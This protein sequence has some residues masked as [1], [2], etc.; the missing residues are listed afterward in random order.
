MVVSGGVTAIWRW[1]TGR[2]SGSAEEGALEEPVGVRERDRNCGSGRDEE[3]AV[4]DVWRSRQASTPSAPAESG[5]SAAAVG[6]AVPYAVEA[7]HPAER[8]RGIPCDRTAVRSPDDEMREQLR[9][10]GAEPRTSEVERRRIDL[11]RR[12]KR[13]EGALM[14]ETRPWKS[15]SE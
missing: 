6:G 5:C 15:E 1:C 11:A 9:D 3:D 10:V 8:L 14:P 4:E 2:G 12:A 13:E 7:R